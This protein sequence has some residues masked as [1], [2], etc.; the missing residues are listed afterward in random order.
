MLPDLDNLLSYRNENLIARYKKEYPHAKMSADVALR[1]LMKYIWLCNL[2]REAVRLSPQDETLQFTCVMHEEMNDIDHMWHCF[3]MFTRDYRD[4]CDRYLNGD[5]FHHQ[6]ATES[7]LASD[8]AYEVELT[9]YLSFIAR[10]LGE[11]T[12]QE[13]FE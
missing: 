10:H 2:H 3:L 12:L 11:A 4:F 7:P 8:L 1:E 9:R 6:P 5:F 13:W